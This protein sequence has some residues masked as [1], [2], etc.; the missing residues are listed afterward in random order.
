MISAVFFLWLWHGKVPCMTTLFWIYAD[1]LQWS[2]LLFWES[3]GSFP[4]LL[5][6]FRLFGLS[7]VVTMK[8]V[9]KS[10]PTESSTKLMWTEMVRMLCLS[11]YLDSLSA[12]ERDPCFLSWT[13]WFFILYLL[14][15]LIQ[16]SWI[17]LRHFSPWIIHNH[18]YRICSLVLI[19]SY[20]FSTIVL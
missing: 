1:R 6:S 13:L 19:L 8:L 20:I 16:F 7:M 3:I 2:S 5:F 9:Q 17:L 14:V 15:T 4:F 11:S 12:K 18:Y 10:S